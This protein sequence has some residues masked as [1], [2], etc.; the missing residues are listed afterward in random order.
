[1]K[2]NDMMIYMLLEVKARF[3]AGL[4]FPI[5]G[6]M[7]EKLNPQDSVKLQQ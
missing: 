3:C 1:M 2:I 4:L 7:I 6:N 5:S